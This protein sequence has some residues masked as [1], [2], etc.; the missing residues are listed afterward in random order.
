MQLKT[1]KAAGLDG[2]TPLG[3]VT[4]E[5]SDISQCLSFGYYDWAWCKENARLDV[6]RLGRFLGV[7]DTICNIH[8]FHVL[9][10]S[11]IPI[12]A[13]DVQ[14]VTQL[15]LETD[16]NK[17]ESTPSMIRLL[18]DSNKDSFVMML[19]NLILKIG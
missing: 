10:E 18:I 15:E 1:N 2:Q 7:A 16:T 14:R 6:P 11:G 17:K 9:P 8:S 19:M 12:V 13:G 3:R 4:G 5:N